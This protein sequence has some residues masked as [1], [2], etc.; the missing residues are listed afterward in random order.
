MARTLDL[1]QL[2]SQPESY[3][4]SDWERAF[5]Y[6][7]I[8]ANVAIVKE[9]AQP[10]PDGWPYL[11]V[12]IAPEG[13]E[14]VAKVLS[15]LSDRGIG[16]AVN[17]HKVLPDYIFTY[18]M[19]WNYRETGRFIVDLTTDPADQAVYRREDGWK[20]GAPTDAYLPGYVRR[21]LR[22]FFTNQSVTEPKILVASS[23]DDIQTD[24]LF[25]LESLGQPPPEEH[26]RVAE[27]ISWFLP[28]HYSVVLAS[29]RDLPKFASL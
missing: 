12:K 2:I 24:L 11:Y 20:F 25:S 14:P 27:A 16:M 6:A 15:W 18:G 22:E 1:Y 13:K 28:A 17:P 19:I 29:E 5:L 7:F 4:N 8:E 21:V 10:G 26:R 9:D 3:R 23:K